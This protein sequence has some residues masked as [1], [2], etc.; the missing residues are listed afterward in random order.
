MY[1]LVRLYL[2]NVVLLRLP[3]SRV[4]G[5]SRKERKRLRVVC[6]RNL[7]WTM[8]TTPILDE[9]I[10]ERGRNPRKSEELF[11]RVLST[12]NGMLAC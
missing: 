8:S 2:D 11:K 7:L 6:T 9:A 10:R 3:F 1:I 5:G 12:K 4:G